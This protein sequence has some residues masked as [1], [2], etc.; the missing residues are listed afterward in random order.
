MKR[1]TLHKLFFASALAFCGTAAFAQGTISTI[2]GTGIAG[3]SGDGGS[4]VLAQFSY[5]SGVAVDAS[6]NIFIAD[7][8]NNKIRK[9]DSWGVISSYAG[10]GVAGWTPTMTLNKPVSVFVDAGGEVLFTAW[11][12]DM[13]FYTDPATGA[14]YARFGCGSQGSSGDGGN[15]CLAKTMTPNGSCEDIYGN[16]YIADYGSNRIRRVDAATHIITTIVNGTGATGYAGDG[17]LAMD[18]KTSHPSAVFFDP[19][20]PGQGHLYFSDANNHVVR[21]VDLNTGII[22]TVAGIGGAAGYTGNWGLAT[23]AK[24]RN[25]GNLFI[26]NAKN[27]YI[28]DRGNHAI[29]KMNLE[30]HVISTVA[31]TGTAG[32]SGDG[33]IST[34]AQLSSPQGVWVDNS[35]N[36][37]IADAGNNCIRKVTL[38]VTPTTPRATGTGINGSTAGNVRMYPNPT[39]GIAKINVTED[40][41]NAAVSV[42]NVT[43]QVVAST[44]LDGQYGTLDLTTLP[45]GTYTITL[46]ASGKKHVEK[47]TIN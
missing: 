44:V 45:A 31:G 36:M 10:A 3:F 30:R 2:A 34:Y 43:G 33:D 12:N 4:A 1:N 13:G 8:N 18:A 9:I 37:Y 27:M 20:S 28:C 47:L 7:K 35:G 6:G 38:G 25:P 26:D 16:T 22:T 11:Y 46:K 23:D 42:M 41:V 40:Y 21:K 32:F 5:P 39:D 15:S 19:T 17:G 24:L 14:T 29:R